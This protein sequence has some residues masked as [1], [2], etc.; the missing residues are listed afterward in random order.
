[1]PFGPLRFTSIAVAR[2]RPLRPTRSRNCMA[3]TTTTHRR[4]C[5]LS[6]ILRLAEPLDDYLANGVLEASKAIGSG[7]ETQAVLL[8]KHALREAGMR[9]YRGWALGIVT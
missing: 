9:W 4:N 7:S 5:C 3:P 1:M 6:T 8:K 2:E